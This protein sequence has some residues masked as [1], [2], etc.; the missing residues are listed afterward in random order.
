MATEKPPDKGQPDNRHIAE[1][2]RS[3]AVKVSELQQDPANARKHNDRNLKA[4]KAS[5]SKFGQRKPIVVQRDGMV[6]RAGN[7]T[8]QAAKA[9][10]WKTVAA[11]VL[12]DD[13]AT[14]AQFA[15][16]DNRTAE[17][18]EWDAPVLG[19]ILE[20]FDQ[21]TRLDLGFTAT[22]LDALVKG[23]VTPPEAPPET[24]PKDT[25][26]DGFVISYNLIFD[27]E[28]QQDT[29]YK[30]LRE[31]KKAHPDCGTV[32]A[33]LMAHIAQSRARAAEA[34]DPGGSDPG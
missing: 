11:V 18:A 2:I 25:S 22:E 28:G 10:G 3:L 17:L 14:A 4:I 1:P 29:F 9:L 6:V 30:W 7:G 15:I 16:A 20:S 13:N 19:S 32:A 26:P 34:A 5:L 27:D 33:R 21:E 8:L 31:L 23:A 24:E 12:D